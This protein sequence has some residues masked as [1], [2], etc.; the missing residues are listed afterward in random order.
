VLKQH[1]SPEIWVAAGEHCSFLE[2]FSYVMSEPP[3]KGELFAESDL[4][5]IKVMFPSAIACFC[6]CAYMHACIYACMNAYIHTHTYAQKFAERNFAERSLSLS[7]SL[8]LMCA[9]V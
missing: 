3:S 7:L 1:E 2:K 8:S 4:P 5:E 6:T 9:F